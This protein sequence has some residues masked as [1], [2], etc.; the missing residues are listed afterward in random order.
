MSKN[1]LPCIVRAGL[2]DGLVDRRSRVAAAS[3]A[4]ATPSVELKLFNLIYER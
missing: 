1:D 2:C 3:S 4:T